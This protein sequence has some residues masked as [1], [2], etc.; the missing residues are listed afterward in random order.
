MKLHEFRAEQRLPVSIREAWDFLSDPHNLARITPPEM[1]FTVTSEVPR[2]M[3]PGLIIMY[4]V[5]PL[6]GVPVTWVTEITQMVEPHLFVDEQRFGPYRFWHHQH[7]LREIEGGVEM[8]D[9][10]HYLLPSV[11]GG[12][13]VQRWLV[14]PQLQTIFDHRRQVLERLFGSFPET[15]HPRSMY[16]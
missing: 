3:H 16:K 9:I 13:L 11:P 12:R 4:K 1:A 7:H 14:G 15:D 2:R 5:R 10:V 8:T 6:F